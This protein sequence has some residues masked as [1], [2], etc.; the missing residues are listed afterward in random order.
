LFY[1][2]VMALHYYTVCYIYPVIML[3]LMT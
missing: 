1:L 3:Q 2:P